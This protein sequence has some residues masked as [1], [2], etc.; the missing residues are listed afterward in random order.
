MVVWLNRLVQGTEDLVVEEGSFTPASKKQT[1]ENQTKDKL[2]VPDGRSVRRAFSK[3]KFIMMQIRRST[4]QSS[5]SMKIWSK[6]YHHIWSG[7]AHFPRIMIASQFWDCKILMIWSACLGTL[8]NMI[9]SYVWP[10]MVSLSILCRFEIGFGIWFWQ[11]K[12]GACSY[13]SIL[14]SWL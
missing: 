7:N 11:S 4:H 6:N 2:V 12:N 3:H 13:S 14:H 8:V 5:K 1:A 9:V 10:T